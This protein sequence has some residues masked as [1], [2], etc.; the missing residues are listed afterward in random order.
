MSFS[1]N[2]ISTAVTISGAITTAP[3]VTTPSSTQAVITK[4]LQGNAGNQNIHTVTAGKTFYLFGISVASNSGADQTVL[5]NSNAG[6][7]LFKLTVAPYTTGV[8]QN[9][10]PIAVYTAAQNVIFNGSANTFCTVWGIEL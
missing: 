5:I 7:T 4:Y 1:F 6:A 2:G 8:V 10:A 3:A 9:A